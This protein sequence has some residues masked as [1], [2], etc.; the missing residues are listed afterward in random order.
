MIV[1]A[2]TDDNCTIGG[3][4]VEEEECTSSDAGFK[5]WSIDCDPF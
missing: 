4:E 3:V 5:A 1:Y 2:Y